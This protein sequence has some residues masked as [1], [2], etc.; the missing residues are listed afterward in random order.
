[1]SIVARAW[2]FMMLKHSFGK[3]M[4]TS[5]E[6]KKYSSRHSQLFISISQHQ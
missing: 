4:A 6:L 1:M 5:S 3:D 2:F